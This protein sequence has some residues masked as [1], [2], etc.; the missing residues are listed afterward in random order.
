MKPGETVARTIKRLGGRNTGGKSAASEQRRQAWKKKKEQQAD[1]GSTAGEASAEDK[2]ADKPEKSDLLEMI[3][4]ADK[5]LLLNGEMDVYQDTFEK[6]SF[7]VKSLSESAAMSRPVDDGLDMFADEGGTKPSPA[8]SV[9]KTVTSI[10][11]KGNYCNFVIFLDK[12]LIPY[13]CSSCCCCWGNT[14]Q[15]KPNA[16]SFQI[17]SGWNLAGIFVR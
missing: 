6:L 16:P 13:C 12:E 1:A 14:I 3:G 8:A 17:E 5:L 15:K 11:E 9:Q 7:K 2:V 10:P 4:C